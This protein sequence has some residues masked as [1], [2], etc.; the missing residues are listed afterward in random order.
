METIAL[1]LGKTDGLKIRLQSRASRLSLRSNKRY[2]LEDHQTDFTGDLFLEFLPFVMEAEVTWG[3][4]QVRT[5]F[6]NTQGFTG[7][8]GSQRGPGTPGER[9]GPGR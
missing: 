1:V 4:E 7:S 5:G 6:T 2:T 8:G 9:A 3:G